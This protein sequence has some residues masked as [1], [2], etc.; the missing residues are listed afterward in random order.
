MLTLSAAVYVMCVHDLIWITIAQVNK[1]MKG[2]AWLFTAWLCGSKIEFT[3]KIQ[4]AD[5]S[6]TYV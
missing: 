5:A 4:T 1:C 6:A 2:S 3:C